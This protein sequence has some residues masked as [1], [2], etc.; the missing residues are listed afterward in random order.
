MILIDNQEIIIPLHFSYIWVL[1][2]GP[3]VQG[4]VVPPQAEVALV[5]VVKSIVDSLFS[6]A[7]MIC[8][9]YFLCK[10]HDHFFF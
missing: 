2:V 9:S 10:K 3:V 8:H 6:I 5:Q 4:Q 1:V 7:Q